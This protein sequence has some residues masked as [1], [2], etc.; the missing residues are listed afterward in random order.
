MERATITEP[1]KAGDT[2][3]VPAKAGEATGT[4]AAP[5]APAAPAGNAPAPSKSSEVPK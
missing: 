3:G 2:S 5:A 1:A 4:P